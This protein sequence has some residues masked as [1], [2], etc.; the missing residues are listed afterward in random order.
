VTGGADSVEPALV[1][2][3]MFD[4]GGV[5]ISVD[6]DR[7][8]RL[9]AAR[10]GCEFSDLRARFAFDDA[11]TQHEQGTLDASGYFAALRRMLE[12]DLSDDDLRA[13]WNDIYA[14]P[15]PGMGAMLAAAASRFP[16]FAFTNSNPTHKR[17][18]AVRFANELSVF[19]S[20][21]VSSDLGVRKPEPEAFS[22]V[23]TRAGLPASE[24]LFFDDTSE[25]IDGARRAGMQ[26]VLV[27]SPSDVRRT[28]LQLGVSDA[29]TE[30]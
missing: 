23:A 18:W 27:T 14:G 9:W 8:L 4:L 5:V 29:A 24:L 11:Y 28:L 6:F 13:G 21:F 3:L 1:G 26:A 2:G 19:R 17:V 30:T 20:V 22:A 25:N 15:I 16:L 10:A 7:A 12:V